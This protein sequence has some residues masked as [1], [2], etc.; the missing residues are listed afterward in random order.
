MRHIVSATPL[1]AHRITTTPFPAQ[2]PEAAKQ[3]GGIHI[4]ADAAQEK[5]TTY[6]DSMMRFQFIAPKDDVALSRQTLGDISIFETAVY[7]ADRAFCDGWLPVPQFPARG[8]PGWEIVVG[9]RII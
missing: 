8:R 6:V 1:P 7:L 3:S 4:A 9:E 5:G 2:T